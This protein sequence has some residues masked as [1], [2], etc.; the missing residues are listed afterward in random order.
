MASC[1]RCSACT[2]RHRAATRVSRRTR[3]K[4]TSPGRCA[5]GSHSPRHRARHQGP[6]LVYYVSNTTARRAAWHHHEGD[7]RNPPRISFYRSTQQPSTAGAFF[8]ITT[9]SLFWIYLF[10][11]YMPALAGWRADEYGA[12]GKMHLK[13]VRERGSSF[14]EHCRYLQQRGE[15]SSFS[16][17]LPVVFGWLLYFYPS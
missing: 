1:A 16:K 7:R 3:H 5:S 13:G 9:V 14:L 10:L 4:M 8:T 6:A 15:E 2:T 17:I 12:G 11:D